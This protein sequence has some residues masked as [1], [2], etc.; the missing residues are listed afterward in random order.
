[1][2]GTTLGMA[3][4]LGA[5]AM[6]AGWRGG[7][8]AVLALVGLAGARLDAGVALALVSVAAASIVRLQR[9]PPNR[10]GM[11]AAL[12]F[13]T[14]AAVA[15]YATG[16]LGVSIADR[17]Q[18]WV[19]GVSALATAIFEFGARAR[20]DGSYLESGSAW[21]AATRGGEMRQFG[22]ALIP[23][24]AAVSATIAG[25]TAV[26][27]ARFQARALTRWGGVSAESARRAGDL[28]LATGALASVGGYLGSGIVAGPATG[29]FGLAA[30]AGAICV[31]FLRERVVGTAARRA[32][33]VL[34]QT[35]GS[36][37]R[38]TKRPSQ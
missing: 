3:F 9:A 13:A 18:W 6:L 12:L 31:V 15:G 8:I 2:T 33:K 38:H 34:V 20:R 27:S 29:M 21:S 17:V 4:L 30:L 24:V 25:L 37:S 7:V 11:P 36:A 14:F 28:P 10:E 22:I 1:M 5:L 32:S 19:F 26:T 35:T 16:R 23:V